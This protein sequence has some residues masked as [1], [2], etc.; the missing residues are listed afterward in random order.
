MPGMPLQRRLMGPIVVVGLIAAACG[1]GS[2]PTDAVTPPPIG[3]GA[4]TD[5]PPASSN[6]PPASSNPPTTVGAQPPA[7]IRTAVDAVQAVAA[8]FGIA[9]DA[10][11]I[12][13]DE[14]VTWSDGSLGCPQPGT[15][16]TQAL[17]SGRR[18]IVAA[19]G[20][21]YH[22][23]GGSDGTLFWCLDP[24]PPLPGGPGNQ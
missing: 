22:F 6:P 9:A 5:L 15:A 8:R 3:P 17:V 10:V 16:Y 7:V 21:Q 18:V 14:E 24:I 11:E 20:N 23:H 13:V 1:G 19:A 2:A 12:V 4:S